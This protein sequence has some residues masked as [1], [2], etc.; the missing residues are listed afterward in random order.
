MD[1][2]DIIGLDYK[3]AKEILEHKGIKIANIKNT[4]PPLIIKISNNFYV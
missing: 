4:A 3:N 1:I 2:P